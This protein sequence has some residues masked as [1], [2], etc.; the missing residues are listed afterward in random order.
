MKKQDLKTAIEDG[1]IVAVNTGYRTP[2]KFP[3]SCAKAKVIAVDQ[4]RRVYSGARYDFS[5]HIARDGVRVR[6]ETQPRYEV[7]SRPLLRASHLRDTYEDTQDRVVAAREVI[8]PWDEYVSER[9]S[10]LAAERDRYDSLQQ[11]A[12]KHQRCVLR[13]N[14]ILG[15]HS[16]SVRHANPNAGNGYTTT[17]IGVSLTLAAAEELVRRL[18]PIR[19][20]L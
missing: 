2:G 9:D 16:A 17:P 18:T 5:G 4:E 11:V 20:P 15:P 10:H 13:L 14:E 19:P 6:F 1:T 7:G 12:A 8:L 3:L